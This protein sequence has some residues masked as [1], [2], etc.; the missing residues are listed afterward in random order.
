MSDDSVPYGHCQCGCGKRTKL[1][2]RSRPYLGHAKGEPVP[3]IHGHAGHQEA[4]RARRAKAKARHPAR[5]WE[6]VQKGPGCWQWMAGKD[7]RG[8]GLYSMGR[9]RRSYLAHRMAYELAKGSIPEGL[10]LDHLCR[11]P[12]CVN[13]AHLQ[14]VTNRTNILRGVGE[15]AV[16]ALKTHCKYG[17]EFDEVN[18][19]YRPNGHRKCRECARQYHRAWCSVNKGVG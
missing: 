6:K 2:K 13:P 11:N 9:A 3:Y 7:R 10:V 1:A 17:H 8:Y 12:S 19:Y 14:A 18:T 16:N 15:S 4:I 5:F